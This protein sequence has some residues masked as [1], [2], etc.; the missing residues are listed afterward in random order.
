[1]DD[2]S[3]PERDD[4]RPEFHMASLNGRRQQ[5]AASRLV[6][7]SGALF[8]GLA[9]DNTRKWALGR[10]RQSDSAAEASAN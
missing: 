3:H 7:L 10:A 6:H 8:A 5:H 1:M 2:D 4:G 9:D